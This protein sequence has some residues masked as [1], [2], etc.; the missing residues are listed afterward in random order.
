MV[1][2]LRKSKE[3]Y[4]AQFPKLSVFIEQKS[5]LRHYC[6]QNAKDEI[7]IRVYKCNSKNVTH[8][9]HF[10]SEKGKQNL[11]RSQFQE[12]LRKLR[13][14]QNDGFLIKKPCMHF[15]KER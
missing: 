6:I 9:S 15:L 3:N 1:K 11:R 14:R 2:I 5:K 4:K 7:R 8:F 13:L 12:K 10:I